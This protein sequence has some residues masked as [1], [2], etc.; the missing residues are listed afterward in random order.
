MFIDKIDV[1]L[2]AGR[3]G[4]GCISFRRE[5]YVP[6][7]GPNGG[8]GGN[9]GNIYF[10]GDSCK[11]TLLDLSYMPKFKAEDGE[12][13]LSSNK[14]GKSGQDL[15]IKIPLGTL[16]FKKGELLAD[17]KIAGERVL[18]VKGGRGGRGNASFKTSNH[19][20][21]RIA[22]KG[23]RGE[24]AEINLEIRLIADVSFV[25]LPNAGKSTLISQVSAVKPKIASYPFTTLYP[26]LGVVNYKGKHF[27]AADI[28]GIIEGAHKGKGLGFEFL[29]HIQRTRVLVHLIDIN[30]FDGKE[31]YEN[32][33]IVNNELKKYSKYIVKKHVIVVLN[34]IDFSQT[35]KNIKKFKKCL[36]TQKVFEIS[37]IT[38]E[39]IDALLKEIVKELENPIIFNQEEEIEIIPVKKY[40]YEPEFKVS[41]VKNG[42]F[43]VMGS[44]V[45]KLTEMTKF[46]ED[47]ALRRYQNILK[48]MGL[49]IELKKMGIKH[50]DIVRIGDF[51]FTFK[52]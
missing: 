12:N 24:S 48:K 51:E 31:P 52:K 34:K 28:P 42:V 32:Y 36:K 1:F 13:G 44:K 26:N 15:V 29:R 3:G 5:K 46:S 25:G 27:V 14:F 22:E 47:E 30:G 19:T 40:T 16:V 50:G 2:V 39:G 17:V 6:Y 7:G 33:K 49:E 45:E 9:G 41:V 4:D 38:G 8:N 35:Q 23:E 18:V 10:E 20:A 11:T 21:P 37:A 43:E